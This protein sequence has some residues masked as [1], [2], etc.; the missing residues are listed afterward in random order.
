MRS[1]DSQEA[2][3]VFQPTYCGLCDIVFAIVAPQ[4]AKGSLLML[5]MSRAVRL[6]GALLISAFLLVGQLNRGSITGTVTDN[7]GSVIP[8]VKLTLRNA[9][10]G[11]VYEAAANENGQYNAPNLPTGTYDITFEAPSFKK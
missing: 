7:S 9:A 6:V 5:H 10:T 1:S 2:C 11:A 8:N 3:Y 4:G